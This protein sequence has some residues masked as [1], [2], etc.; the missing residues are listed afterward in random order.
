M[1]GTFSHFLEPLINPI[2]QNTL[3]AHFLV[4][5]FNCSLFEIALR[6]YMYISRIGKCEESDRERE[7]LRERF[8]ERVWEGNWGWAHR[9]SAH[10]RE[11]TNNTERRMNECIYNIGIRNNYM[12]QYWKQQPNECD[13]NIILTTIAHC[14]IIL[15]PISMSLNKLGKT[16]YKIR[17]YPC[18]KAYKFYVL[19]KIFCNNIKKSY[20]IL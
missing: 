17:F 15:L 5:A 14:C 18:C 12:G 6:T 1:H 9:M 7:R 16:I 11:R 13:K 8:R 19:T 2:L 20:T 10:S 3:K 4:P